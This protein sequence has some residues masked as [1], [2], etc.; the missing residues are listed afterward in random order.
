MWIKA[1]F[2]G[3]SFFLKV[4]IF[5]LYTLTTRGKW[6]RQCAKSYDPS[7]E[8]LWDLR[9]YGYWIEKLKKLWKNWGRK[10]FE[11]KIEKW[12]VI[13]RKLKNEKNTENRK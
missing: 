11:I 1:L 6:A 8:T 2:A 13:K 5:R 7:F 4:I 12:E 3:N 9:I 10:S